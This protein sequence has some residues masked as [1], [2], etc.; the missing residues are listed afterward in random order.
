MRQSITPLGDST[1]MSRAG[2]HGVQHQVQTQ[3]V[4]MGQGV[5]PGQAQ[6]MAN[7]RKE[8]NVLFNNSLNTFYLHLYGVMEQSDNDRGNLMPPH[9]GLFPDQLQGIF[10]LYHPTNM[11][12][13]NTAFVTSSGWNEKSIDWTT[14]DLCLASP[15]LPQICVM[16][17]QLYDRSVSC[18]S[19]SMTDLCL[20]PP[21]L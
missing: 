8:E 7:T 14:I 9:Y 11:I 21:T 17:L 10:Y 20:A 6:S 3:T 4:F 12:I 16:L 5:H 15:T 19:N 1:N 2:I 13:H 18:S